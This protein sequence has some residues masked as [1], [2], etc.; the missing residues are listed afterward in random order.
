MT[1]R[2][3]KDDFEIAGHV[4]RFED[5]YKA[6]AVFI[7]LGYGTGIYSGGK[8]MGRHWRL[9]PFG[10]ESTDQG[11]L[12]K[13][14]D[15]YRQMRDW[16]KGGGALE[17]DATICDQ[18]I[19]VEACPVSVGPSAGKIKLESKEEMAKRGIESPNRAD[20]LALTFAFPVMSKAQKRY[21]EIKQNVK[22]YNPLEIPKQTKVKPV[23]VGKGQ[24]WHEL[25]TK[26]S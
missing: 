13:R 9:I 12:N 25:M 14:A 22:E 6:D 17:D 7:D 5:E 23:N 16:L 11:F 15:M 20:A 1:Y 21:Q 26:R 8:Q 3:V 24:S 4:A 18:L 10:G 2:S 19:S